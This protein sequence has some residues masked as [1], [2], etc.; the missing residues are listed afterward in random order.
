MP[1]GVKDLEAGRPSP[2]GAIVSEKEP[3]GFQKPTLNEQEL[4]TRLDRVDELVS[5]LIDDELAEENVRELETLLVDSPEARCQYVGMIQLHTDLIEY[6][7]PRSYAAG[8][9]PILAHLTESIDVVPPSSQP[10]K[11]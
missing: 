4:A 9:S 3:F 5:L 2:K 7:N 11:D 1:A 10:S 8:T 6:Y